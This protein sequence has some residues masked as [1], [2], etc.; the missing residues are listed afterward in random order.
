RA[1]MNFPLTTHRTPVYVAATGIVSAIAADTAGSLT[2]LR[3]GTHGIGRAKMLKTRWVDEI[4]VAEVP[5]STSELLQR[6]GAPASWPRT[7][8][9]SLIA[10]GEILSGIGDLLPPESLAF[11]SANTVGGMDK[12]EAAYSE[13]IK[14]ATK[15]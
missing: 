13:I 14:D 8:A 9:L 1:A 12:T 10:V 3:A 15:V 11:L 5:Y 7:A 2:A 4:P 6:N